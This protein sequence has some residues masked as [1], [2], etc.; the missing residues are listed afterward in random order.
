[1]NR[2]ASWSPAASTPSSCWA[3]YQY[4]IQAIGRQAEEIDQLQSLLLDVL[5]RYNYR[6]LRHSAVAYY[7]SLN[8]LQA[9][10]NW[11][12][13]DLVCGSMDCHKTAEAAACQDTH[14][15]LAASLE[16]P[17]KNLTDDFERIKAD[18][19]QF[20]SGMVTLNLL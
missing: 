1:M 7:Q 3:G 11:L 16:R 9:R 17:I 14:F 8:R 4:Q 15:G 13:R 10:L 5:N 18:C 12:N 6:S 2:T 19:I 20:L